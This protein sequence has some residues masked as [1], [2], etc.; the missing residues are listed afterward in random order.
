MFDE[1]SELPPIRGHE[2]S[3]PLKLGTLPICTRPYRYPYFQKD[4]IEKQVH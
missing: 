3:I 4:E 2:H 1:P